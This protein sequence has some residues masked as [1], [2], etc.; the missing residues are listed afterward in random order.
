MSSSPALGAAELEFRIDFF[1]EG[2]LSGEVAL[3]LGT[4]SL[5][6]LFGTEAEG[7]KGLSESEEPRTGGN[8]FGSFCRNNRP[9]LKSC[10]RD[11][12]E[13]GRNPA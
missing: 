5:A 12:V 8:G 11:L 10:R 13:Q 1:G 2:C 4:S 6:I 3:H 9:A 7:L